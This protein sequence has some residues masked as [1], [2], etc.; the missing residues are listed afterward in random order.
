M[1]II[2]GHFVRLYLL[3]LRVSLHVDPALDPADPRPWVLCFWHGEQLPLLAWKRRRPTVA[4]VSHS[5]DGQM[6]S[7]ALR[8]QGLRV[9]RGSSSRGGSGGLRSMCEIPT[10]ARCGVRGRRSQGPSFHG[11]SGRM[12]RRRPRLGPS[13]PDGQRSAPWDHPAE[14]LGSISNSTSLLPCG[15]LP[16]AATGARV[17][18][19]LGLAISRSSADATPC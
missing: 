12:L 3:T 1:K 7:M 10:R 19:D 2:L 9:T 18:D 11:G 13:G 17:A 15:G 4:L 5:A 6:Q 8:I 16:R 14:S